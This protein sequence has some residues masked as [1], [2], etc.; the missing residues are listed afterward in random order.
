MKVWKMIPLLVILFTISSCSSSSSVDE[1]TASAD[2]STAAV[3]APSSN[4]VPAKTTAAPKPAEPKPVAITIPAGS[5]VMVILSSSLN[6]GKNNTGDEF[7]GSLDQP[8][9]VN[10]STIFDR[11]TKVM[12]KVVDAQGSGR[13]KGV[14]SMRLAITSIMDNGKSTPIT[15]QP[16]VSEAEATKGRDAA[17]V[18][19]GAGLGAAIG[20]IAGGKKGAATGAVIGGAAGGGTVLATKGKEVDFPAESK[21]T[22]TLAEDVTVRR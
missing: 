5:E 19:G 9:R 10:G 8:L 15:T 2:D 16:F 11:G 7:E 20:A 17:V 22:F 21:I 12:G 18:G 1:P 3:S 4:D 13:V 14:A 6:S